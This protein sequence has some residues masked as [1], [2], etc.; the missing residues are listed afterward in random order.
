MWKL[1]F[2]SSVSLQFDFKCPIDKKLSLVRLFGTKPLYKEMAWFN[3]A[4]MSN[5]ASMN[6]R[7]VASVL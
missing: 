3:N 1:Y 6:Y 2:D 7:T 5:R 4:V